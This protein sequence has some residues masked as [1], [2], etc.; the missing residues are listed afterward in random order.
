MK[1]KKQKIKVISLEA[2]KEKPKPKNN[3]Y[4]DEDVTKAIVNFQKAEAPKEKHKIFEENIMPAFDKLIKYHYFKI[5]VKRD[6]EVVHDCMSFL[7]EQLNKFDASQHDRGFPYFNVIVKNYFIQ[8]LKNEEKKNSISKDIDSLNDPKEIIK[9][10]KDCIVIDNIEDSYDNEEFIE[11]LKSALPKWRES[12]QK[13]QEKAV[14]E[15]L[16]VLFENVENF[17]NYNKKII[18]FYIKEITG[19]NT[20]QIAINLNKVKKKF[21]FLKKKFQRG[22]I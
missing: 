7:Y 15:A 9:N 12:F 11:V 18:Y 8:K 21:K 2:I 10:N 20:K 13:D 5:P 1:K 19:M 16:T 3:L 22:N 14:V 17:D 6:P 4:F